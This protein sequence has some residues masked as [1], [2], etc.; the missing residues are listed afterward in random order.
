MYQNRTTEISTQETAMQA[1]IAQYQTLL[2][3][4]FSTSDELINTDRTL[5]TDV[6]GT[7][8]FM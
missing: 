1:R 7:G 8:T 5:F 4:E 3:S 2:Q 6:G